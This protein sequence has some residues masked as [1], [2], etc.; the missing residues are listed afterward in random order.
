MKKKNIVLIGA[1]QLGSRHLQALTKLQA[2]A[3]ITVIDPSRDS[4]DICKTRVHEIEG[5]D[6]H[7]FVYQQ[8]IEGL[9][10][11]DFAVVA[12]SANVRRQVVEKL[13]ETAEVRA[14]LLEKVLFQSSKDCIEVGRLLEEKDVRAWVNAPRRMWPCYRALKSFL[15]QDR[16]LSFVLSGAGWGLACNSYHMLD[17]FAWFTKGRIEHI[18]SELIETPP[19]ASKR[20]GYF[21][22][23]GTFGG[24]FSSGSIFVLS[25]YSGMEK[26]LEVLIETQTRRI[27]ISEK[28]GKIR[29]I[30]GDALPPEIEALKITP[31]YQSNLTNLVAEALLAGES[32]GLTPYAEA[33]ELHQKMLDAFAKKF[34]QIKE[35]GRVCPIT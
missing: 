5:W 28:H 25:D 17:L 12:T 35:G 19:I 27:H 13:L 8:N 3:H 1:G 30:S 10:G 23:K 14:L 31:E 20:P 21:E 6:R 7:T 11:V 16:I 9:P 32:C 4:L 15:E 2:P 22:L 34:L 26:D 24:Q 18:S 33:S 29:L